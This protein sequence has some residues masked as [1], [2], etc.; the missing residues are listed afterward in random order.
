MIRLFWWRRIV[1]RK[2]TTSD[3][4]KLIH[5]DF[6][7]IDYSVA[8]WASV[9][10]FEAK[11]T[12]GILR[13]PWWYSN[14]PWNMLHVVDW[15]SDWW[16]GRILP[17]VTYC[18]SLQWWWRRYWPSLFVFINYHSNIRTDYSHRLMTRKIRPFTKTGDIRRTLMFSIFPTWPPLIDIRPVRL[19]DDV[20]FL[21]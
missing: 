21:R 5:S 7:L 14:D 12:S 9:C 18:G 10:I 19:F 8:W 3:C 16:R 11:L 13:R 6:I 1:I 20:T 4:I 2:M 17:L 15:F